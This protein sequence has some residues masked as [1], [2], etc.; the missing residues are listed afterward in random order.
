MDLVGY[1]WSGK[2]YRSIKGINFI[3]LGLLYKSK[4]DRLIPCS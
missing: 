1:F 2:H 4:S 3:T